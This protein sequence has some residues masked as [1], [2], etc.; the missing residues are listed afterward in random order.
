VR[1]S[2][3]L[4]QKVPSATVSTQPSRKTPER[5]LHFRPP[6]SPGR[7][8]TGLPGGLGL[9][10]PAAPYLGTEQAALARPWLIRAHSR[11]TARTCPPWGR[12]GGP[13]P[14]PQPGRRRLDTLRALASAL[15]EQSGPQVPCAGHAITTGAHFVRVKYPNQQRLSPKQWL[16]KALISLVSAPKCTRA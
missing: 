11:A 5:F 16:T 7:P 14:T 8:L 9:R 13:T 4:P 15:S 1:S 2:A 3:L 12:P 10:P 6:N